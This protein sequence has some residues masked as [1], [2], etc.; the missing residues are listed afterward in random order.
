[1]EIGQSK[2]QQK[3]KD[4]MV[5]KRMCGY[6]NPEEKGSILMTDSIASTPLTSGFNTIPGSTLLKIHSWQH[7]V[8]SIIPI[9][10]M[11]IYTS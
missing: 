9:L 10:A 11:H 1:M 8:R 5:N 6:G 4:T 3:A 7:Y 2:S